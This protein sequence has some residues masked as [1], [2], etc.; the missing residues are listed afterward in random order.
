[1]NIRVLKQ[2]LRTIL[3][4]DFSR[5]VFL[6][7]PPGIGKSDA[8]RQVAAEES[9]GFIDLRLAQC[10]PTDV[11]GVLVFDPTDRTARWFASSSLPDERRHGRRGILFLDE[12]NLAPPSV[13]A[14]GYQLILDRRV[15]DYFLPP[16]WRVVAAGNR[17]EDRAG[18]YRLP[19]PLANRFVQIDVSPDLEDWKGWAIDQGIHPAVTA[20]LS[21]KPDLFCKVPDQIRDDVFPTPRTWHFVS[22]LLRTVSDK[23]QRDAAIRGCVG[24]GPGVE[25][26]AFA[27]LD[28]ESRRLLDAILAGENLRAPELSLQFLV[29]SHLVERLKD[30]REA[31]GRLLEYC[32]VLEAEHAVA[33]LRDALRAQ[34]SLRGHPRFSEAAAKFGRFLL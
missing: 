11:R 32:F 8:V 26:C 13:M 22:D 23:A 2:F 15:G 25:F 24:E 17:V 4:E 28:D 3:R 6:F 16:G 19:A 30:D 27:S 34:P 5:A 12:I 1:V 33:L 10:D 31:G 21:L 14:A 18:I 7:G 20:F 9:I 29:N